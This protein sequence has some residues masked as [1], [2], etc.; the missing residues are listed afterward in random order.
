MLM[1]REEFEI[2]WDMFTKKHTLKK[3][4]ADIGG[5]NII[6]KKIFHAMLICK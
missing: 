4:V 2:H 6:K 1:A 5:V 3:M